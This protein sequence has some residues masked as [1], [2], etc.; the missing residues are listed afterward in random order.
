M[1]TVEIS[2]DSCAKEMVSRGDNELLAFRDGTI[3]DEFEPSET[4]DAN[5]GA[6]DTS[7]DRSNS[8]VF[9]QVAEN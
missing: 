1:A 3:F 5:V 6:G 2:A 7:E 4:R 9:Q 8:T